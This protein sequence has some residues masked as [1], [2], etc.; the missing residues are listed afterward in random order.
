M[1]DHAPSRRT[2]YNHAI[3]ASNLGARGKLVGLTISAHMGP[4]ADDAYP[5]LATIAAESSIA[6][7]TTVVAQ[8]RD[9]EFL[10]LLAVDRGNAGK[11]GRGHANRYLGRIPP[12]VLARLTPN[13]SSAWTLSGGNGPGD[14]GNGSVGAEEGSSSGTGSNQEGTQPEGNPEGWNQAIEENPWPYG[15]SEVHRGA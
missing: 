15:H 3:L 5:S 10:G 6:S 14:G 13:Q 9:M 7:K 8:E 11:G 2:V 1:A 4:D 12:Y